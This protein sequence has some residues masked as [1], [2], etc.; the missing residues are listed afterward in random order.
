MEYLGCQKS[1]YDPRTILFAVRSATAKDV[2]DIPDEYDM[3][4][5][6][7]GN[8]GNIGSC[9]GWAAKSLM[10]WTVLKNDELL[11]G[12]SAGSIYAHSWD[13]MIIPPSEGSTPI[14]I[15]KTLQKDGACTELCSPTDTVAPFELDDCS[16]WKEIASN[17]KIGTYRQVPLDVDSMKAA[18]WGTTQPQPYG[19]PC[20]LYI[21]IPVYTSFSEGGS[22]GIVP[23]PKDGDTL[24]GGH[25]V[26]ISGWKRFGDSYFWTVVNSWGKSWGDNGICYLPFDYPIW[27][28]WMITDDDPIKPDPEPAPDPP[29]PEPEPQGCNPFTRLFR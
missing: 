20:P 29:E 9:C 15:M 13:H 21:A 17:Y 8:Q 14:A 2:K 18:M 10:E 11:M 25:A 27:E 19:E 7:P 5:K 1:P 3:G 28:A 22:T 26:I 4:I 12:L 23:M 6:C 16:N 24:R